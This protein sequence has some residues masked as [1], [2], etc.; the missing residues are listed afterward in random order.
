VF[1]QQ[2]RNARAQGPRGRKERRKGK[3]TNTTVAGGF[4]T[5]GATQ[6]SEM[7]PPNPLSFLAPFL[8]PLRPCIAQ[9]QLPIHV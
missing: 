6:R 7:P 8:A 1:E 4:H 2:L 9:L 3:A 5:A